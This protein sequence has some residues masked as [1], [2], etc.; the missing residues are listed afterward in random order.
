MR[1]SVVCACRSAP[2]L[3]SRLTMSSRPASQ[4]S[5]LFSLPFSFLSL[6][7]ADVPNAKC[8]QVCELTDHDPKC[9]HTKREWGQQPLNASMK[10]RANMHM[11]QNT[12]RRAN[13]P[14][15]NGNRRTNAPG[16]PKHEQARERNLC[17]KLQAQLMQAKLMHQTF[18]ITQIMVRCG[19][20]DG[21]AMGLPS[22]S[23]ERKLKTG[24]CHL[25][26]APLSRLT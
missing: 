8:E 16:M 15:M 11:K 3:T 25:L 2:H 23:Y 4:T 14:N 6:P 22:A 20:C 21:A 9:K 7:Q 12:P 10:T 13:T 24:P 18:G 17:T 1:P 26:P 5:N 19:K